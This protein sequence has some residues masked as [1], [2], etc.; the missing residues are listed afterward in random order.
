M[1]IVRCPYCEDYVDVKNTVKCKCG[2][3]F[4]LG[5]K[6]QGILKH[7]EKRD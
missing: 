4:M 7:E 6:T 5:L 2:Q 1:K 3:E